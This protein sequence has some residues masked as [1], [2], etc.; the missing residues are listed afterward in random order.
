MSP[1]T[2]LTESAL[3]ELAEAI[4]AIFATLLPGEE[5]RDAL[6]A[7]QRRAGASDALMRAARKSAIARLEKAVEEARMAA[8]EAGQWTLEDRKSELAMVLIALV[9]LRS[10]GDD[11]VT[12]AEVITE[13]EFQRLAAMFQLTFSADGTPC[14]GLQ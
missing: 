11:D 1:T 2:D 10:A 7:L 12:V 6:W 4:H 9:E 3:E 8:R 14:D 5:R 13:E